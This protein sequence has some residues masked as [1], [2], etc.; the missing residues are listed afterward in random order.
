VSKPRHFGQQLVQRG[1]VPRRLQES[2]DEAERLAFA[3]EWRDAEHR[4][5]LMERAPHRVRMIIRRD[6]ERAYEE[7][8]RRRAAEETDGEA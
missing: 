2:I 4:L 5:D 8:L 6:E 7:E 3:V 1:P